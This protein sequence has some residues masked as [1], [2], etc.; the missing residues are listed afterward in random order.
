MLNLM[1]GC[2]YFPS[3]YTSD[4]IFCAHVCVFFVYVFF[5]EVN[6]LPVCSPSSESQLWR[7]ET[8]EGEV[9]IHTP[10][11]SWGD[12]GGGNERYSPHFIHQQP[13][14]LTQQLTNGS[15]CPCVYVYGKQMTICAWKSIDGCLQRITL[16]QCINWDQRCTICS[17]A[18]CVLR[19]SFFNGVRKR[20]WPVWPL[21]YPT[22]CSVQ[23]LLTREVRGD[24]KAALI[25]W[26]NKYSALVLGRCSLPPN[27]LSVCSHLQSSTV[28]SCLPH[29]AF[30][31]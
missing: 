31:N 12:P 13:Y 18:V 4:T 11:G 7:A 2:F 25:D 5:I 29:T 17:G 14:T 28:T 27:T 24:T 16:N 21:T 30:V 20:V 15:L 6:I 10:I 23:L 8:A 19:V 3:S 22:S 9:Q 1:F 26:V